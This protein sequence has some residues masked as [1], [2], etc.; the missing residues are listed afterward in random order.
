MDTTANKRTVRRVFE[1]G[2]TAG[3]VSCRGRMPHAR[4]G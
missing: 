4:R 3:N 1:E 2:F